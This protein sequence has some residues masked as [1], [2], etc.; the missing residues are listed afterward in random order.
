MH[1]YRITCW[2]YPRRGEE[3]I[4]KN[5]NQNI[6]KFFCKYIDQRYSDLELINEGLYDT[7]FKKYENSDKILKDFIVES[8]EEMNGL[9]LLEI[10]REE[11]PEAIISSFDEIKKRVAS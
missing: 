5:Q 9:E 7:Y 1:A 2:V 11:Y 8:P 10:I 4:E 6:L 3:I